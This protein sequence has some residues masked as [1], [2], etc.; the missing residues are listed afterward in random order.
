MV[1]RTFRVVFL[2]TGLVA[3][4]TLCAQDLPAGKGKEMVASACTACHSSERITA[5]HRTPQEWK[6]VVDRMVLNGAALKNED[7]ESVVQ[8]LAK[9]FSPSNIQIRPLA[10]S[11]PA[12]AHQ[13]PFK[14]VAGV[15]QLME[16]IVIP[17]SDVVWHVASEAPK[18][19]KEWAVVQH[20]ALTLAEAGNL[21]MIGDRA[22]DQGDWMKAAQALIDSA[23]V[24]FRAAEAKNA[25]ELNKAGDKLVITCGNCHRQYK[26]SPPR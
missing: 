13:P 20:S 14:P 15:Y 22:K 18:N 3:A 7:V 25:D 10:S 17:S 1:C 24:V 26:Q 2:L 23:T 5:S 11:G 4:V 12:T 9:N 19:D 16:A 8:Y 21:L 6:D